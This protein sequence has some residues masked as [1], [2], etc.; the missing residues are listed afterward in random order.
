MEMI[1]MANINTQDFASQ[2]G[3]DPRT[4]RKYLRSITPKDEQPGKGSR[5]VLDGNKKS[6]TSHKKRFNEWHAAQLQAAADRA[7]KAAEEATQEVED[8]TESL[9]D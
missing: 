4:V 6:I 1:V 3:T 5:W 9:D 7:A 8:E 2:L